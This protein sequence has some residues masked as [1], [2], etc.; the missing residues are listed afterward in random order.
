MVA[1]GLNFEN[2]TLVG[3]LL[4]DQSLYSGDY[5]AGERSFSLMT[6]VIGRSGRAQRRGRA[7]IQTFTPENPIIRFA[8]QQD[9]EAFYQREME[10][11]QMQ[12]CPPFA[13]LVSLTVIG[14]DE[15]EILR[16]C[17][18]IRDLLRH[19]LKGFERIDLLGPAPYPVVKAAGR[20]RYRLTL[21]GGEDAQ[22]RAI[23]TK[24]LNYCNRE[25]EFRGISVYADRNPL[26]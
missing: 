19:S 12:H 22:V 15:L 23:V 8:A 16:A 5:R 9:Y 10:M 6:Q 3:V 11:R 17:Q 20:Y 14:T 21:R 7:I 4:A 24:L 2:V 26:E 1:K 18:R 13:Q 25:R